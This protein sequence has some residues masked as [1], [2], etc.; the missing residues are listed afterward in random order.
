MTIYGSILQFSSDWAN[1]AKTL[2]YR[3]HYS[4]QRR[5]GMPAPSVEQLIADG[6]LVSIS[7]G[8]RIRRICQLGVC[9]Y[10]AGAL[11]NHR[12][13]VF[14][15]PQRDAQVLPWVGAALGCQRVAAGSFESAK[16]GMYVRRLN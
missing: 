2:S 7:L 1:S 11:P 10:P 13:R 5:G 9:M 14:I 8:R 16:Y 6:Q 4:R 12:R 3:F 15:H